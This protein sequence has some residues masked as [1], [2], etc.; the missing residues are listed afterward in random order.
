M[1][2]PR[3]CWKK[4]LG[5]CRRSAPVLGRS[6]IRLTGGLGK[7]RDTTC[8]HCCARGRALRGFQAWW[9]NRELCTQ[10]NAVV[11][12]Y[13]D[14]NAFVAATIQEFSGFVKQGL[15][16]VANAHVL[17][18]LKLLR[19]CRLGESCIRRVNKIR[20]NRQLF[21]LLDQ[22]ICDGDWNFRCVADVLLDRTELHFDRPYRF[23]LWPCG[24]ALHL[25][26]GIDG[27]IWSCCG[28]RCGLGYRAVGTLGN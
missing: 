6:K 19:R 8:G 12:Q 20:A 24:G 25:R 10:R 11:Q 4:N 1:Q 22:P 7:W 13:F 26:L 14:L 28:R 5:Y 23:L 27:L 2:K 17:S 21:A 9:R 16:I 18:A 15:L 3:E